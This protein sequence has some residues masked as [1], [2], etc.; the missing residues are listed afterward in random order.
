VLGWAFRH[1]YILVRQAVMVSLITVDYASEFDSESISGFIP[2]PWLLAHID[3]SAI[4]GELQRKCYHPTVKSYFHYPIDLM[5]RIVV[6]ACWRHLTYRK[7][8]PSL[9]EEDLYYLFPAGYTGKFP[10][11]STI[12]NFVKNRLGERGLDFLMKRIGQEMVKY[13]RQETIIVDSTPL[14]ASRYSIASVYNP[15][16]KIMMDKAHI[17]HYGDYPLY[18]FHSGGNEADNGYGLELLRIA[19]ELGIE[20]LEVLMDGGY[21]SFEM[22]TVCFENLGVNPLIHLRNGSVI[23]KEATEDKILMAKNRKWKEGGAECTTLKETLMF[24]AKTDK[25]SLVGKYLRNQSILTQETWEEIYQERGDCERKHAQIK[26]TVKFDVYGYRKESRSLYTKL[27]F[28][29]FQMMM[30]GQLV[31]NL[32]N[33]TSLSRYL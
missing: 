28:I 17:L 27:H 9:S 25:R 26:N 32:P 30:L 5:I 11:H 22:R 2:A 29:S 13:I 24:L 12:H 8:E 33:P 21:D 6:L 18:M 15:H 10:A 16:Y 23:Q 19:K 3:L 7:I 14:P 1:L 4:A 20:P 31:N